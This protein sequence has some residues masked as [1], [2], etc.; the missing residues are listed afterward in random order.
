MIQIRANDRIGVLGSSGSGKSNT[1]HVALED[2]RNRGH[3]ICVLDATTEYGHLPNCENIRARDNSPKNLPERLRDSNASVVVNFTPLSQERRER[4]ISDFINTCLRTPRKNAIIIILD[5]AHKYV[6]QKEKKRSRSAINN[7]LSEGRKIGYGSVLIS[8]RC[9]K[10]DKDALTQC[11]I[12]LIHRHHFKADLDYLEEVCRWDGSREEI[13][14]LKT[15]EFINYE[16]KNDAH[17]TVM[18]PLS[19]IKRSGGTVPAHTVIPDI[20]KFYRE[21]RDIKAVGSSS[22]SIIVI[23]FVGVI[24][25]ICIIGTL[26]GLKFIKDVEGEPKSKKETKTKDTPLGEY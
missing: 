7:L 21:Q 5:E 22:K 19:N 3:P 9:A 23:I 25:A 8:Q 13:K 26:L 16:L 10:L 14:G 2:L 6:P 11:D 24:L 4:W 18:S 17:N 15:G 20:K 12:I 1:T